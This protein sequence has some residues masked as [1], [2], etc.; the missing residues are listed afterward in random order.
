[1]SQPCANCDRPLGSR[2]YYVQGAPAPR[3]G[4]CSQLCH[5]EYKRDLEYRRNQMTLMVTQQQQFQQDR[6]VTQWTAKHFQ[7]VP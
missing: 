7:R 1:M 4:L 2:V 3:E 6:Q 5:N